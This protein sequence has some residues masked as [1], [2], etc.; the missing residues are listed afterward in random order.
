MVQLPLGD[1]DDVEE[2]LD[3]GVAGLGIGQDLANVVYGML[4]FEGVFLFFSLYHQGCAD[5]LRGGH[6]VEQ[7]RFPIGR[8]DQDWGLHQKLLD[9]VK[10][11]LGLGHPFKMVGLLQ[12]PIDGETSFAE[13]RDKMVERGE[14][15]YN[16]LYPLYVLNRAHPRDGQDLLWVGFDAMLRNDKTQQHTPWDP[17]S[18]LLGVE[19]NV[20]C[21]EFHKGLV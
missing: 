10:C 6:D 14:A 9:H 18:A 15:P 11:L 8:G 12:K 5:H 7:K 19:L 21:S 2:L 13:A 20:V 17:E 4:H 1:E 3:L 16:S